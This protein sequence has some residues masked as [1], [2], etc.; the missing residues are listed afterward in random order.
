MKRIITALAL[1]TCL[2]TIGTI[3]QFQELESQMSEFDTKMY[4]YQV[5]LWYYQYTRAGPVK[6]TYPGSWFIG[7]NLTRGSNYTLDWNFSSLHWE[8]H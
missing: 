1:A 8:G 4:D 7:N 2:M 6:V 3:I 5:D